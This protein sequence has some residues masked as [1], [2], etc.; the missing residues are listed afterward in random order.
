[1]I[2]T[3]SRLFGNIRM[4]GL[5]SFL[6]G[7]ADRRGPGTETGALRVSAELCRQ[8]SISSRKYTQSSCTAAVFLTSGVS[9]NSVRTRTSK[10]THGSMPFPHRLKGYPGGVRLFWTTKITL[11]CGGDRSS[12][13]ARVASHPDCFL[14]PESRRY[15][16][17]TAIPGVDLD[18]VEQTTHR[19]ITPISDTPDKGELWMRVWPT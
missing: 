2:R 17:G 18:D 11:A 12:I 16:R 14:N 8:L 5:Y 7:L 13:A 15:T 6:S 1:M 9:E 4:A 10:P 3:Q 19:P